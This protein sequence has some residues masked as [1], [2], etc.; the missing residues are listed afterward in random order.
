MGPGHIWSG[1]YLVQ[2]HIWQDINGT[3]WTYLAS[4]HIWSGTY[5]AKGHIWPDI[6]GTLGTYL[7]P[8]H[9]WSGTYLARTKMAGHKRKDIVGWDILGI[10]PFFKGTY[11]FVI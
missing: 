4:G 5:L 7:G 1:T 11:S 8:G 2:G 3:L 10:P 9:K 6:S